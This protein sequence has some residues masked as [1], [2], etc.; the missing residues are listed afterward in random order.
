MWRPFDDDFPF[1]DVGFVDELDFHAFGRAAHAFAE[2][3][4]DGQYVMG[5]SE[6]M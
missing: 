1:V 3:L 2:L 4:H 6:T 5:R